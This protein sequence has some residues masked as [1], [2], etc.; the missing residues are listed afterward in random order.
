[1]P[2]AAAVIGLP[3]SEELQQPAPHTLGHGTGERVRLVV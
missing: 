3:A 1:M 2:V